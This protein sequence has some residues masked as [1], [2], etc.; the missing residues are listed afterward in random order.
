MANFK[1][2]QEML[3]WFHTLNRD[4]AIE[5]F[6][7]AIGQRIQEKG[8]IY[9]PCQVELRT[10]K[11]IPS[12]VSLYKLITTS[13]Y[14]SACALRFGVKQRFK[15]NSDIFYNNFTPLSIQI[16]TR[17]QLPLWDVIE[18]SSGINNIISGKKLYAGDYLLTVD[19]RRVLFERKSIADFISTMSSGFY[20]FRRELDRTKDNGDDLIIIVEEEIHTCLDFKNHRRAYSNT[21]ITPEFV[22]RNVRDIIQKHDNVQFLFVKGRERMKDV[23]TNI[24]RNIINY[25][26]IDLQLAYDLGQI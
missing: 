9:T 10:V 12:I 1:T 3:D 11:T 6:F 5:Y 8:L 15:D 22:F 24:A 7:S 17:E 26:N 14:Y 20:R 18:Y 13:D 2:R 25:N 21:R 23:M 4:E 16:D 19:N